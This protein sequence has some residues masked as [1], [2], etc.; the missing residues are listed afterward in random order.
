[1]TDGTFATGVYGDRPSDRPHEAVRTKQS[2]RRQ[3]EK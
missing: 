3:M 1:V 2:A